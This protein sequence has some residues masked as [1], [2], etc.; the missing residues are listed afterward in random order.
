M[1]QIFVTSNFY[2]S[3]ILKSDLP[4]NFVIP[5]VCLKQTLKYFTVL[6]HI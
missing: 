1:L 6:L 2:F 4:F 5:L 3:N